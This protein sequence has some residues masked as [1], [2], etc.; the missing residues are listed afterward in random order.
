[1]QQLFGS[2]AISVIE[3]L[4]DIFNFKIQW[5]VEGV[6]DPGRGWHEVISKFPLNPKKILRH[7]ACSISRLSLSTEISKIKSKITQILIAAPNTPLPD[8]CSM[9]LPQTNK[10]ISSLTLFNARHQLQTHLIITTRR[11]HVVRLII[12]QPEVDGF[13]RAV[14]S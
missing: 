12:Y 14:I 7:S 5:I 4:S 6:P 3:K 1:M 2:T 10:R 11:V 8:V 13:N 9:L